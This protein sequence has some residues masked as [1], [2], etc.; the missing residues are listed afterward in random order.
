V[1][2]TADCLAKVLGLTRE[3]IDERTTANARALL[4]I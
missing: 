2:H 1:A 4:K 3:V